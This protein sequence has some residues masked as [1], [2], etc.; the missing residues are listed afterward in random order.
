METQAVTVKILERNYKLTIASGEERYIREA[1]ALIDA[2]ARLYGKQYGYRDF[3]DLLAMVA[4]SQIT[5]LVKTQ[6]NLKFKDNE[7]INKLMEVD[8]ILEDGLHPTQN[9]L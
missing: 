8:S 4:L 5:E 3:Q 9:S 7:L 1:A 6:E 2:R